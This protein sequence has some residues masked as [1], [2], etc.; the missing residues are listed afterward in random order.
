MPGSNTPLPTPPRAGSPSCGRCSTPSRTRWPRSAPR[1]GTTTS[2]HRHPTIALPMSAEPTTI[3]ALA[4]ALQARELSALDVTNACLDRIA[5]RDGAINAFVHVCAD[6]ARAQ[7]TALDRELAEGRSRGPL[8]GVPISL[9]DL[10]DLEGV[11]TTAA[12]KVRQG[13]VAAADAAVVAAL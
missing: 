6:S 7:A 10:V 5:Q 1:T 2:A 3:A 12:S 9:K 13:H 8:H 4:S 11:P